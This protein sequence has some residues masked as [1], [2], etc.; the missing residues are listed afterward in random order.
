MVDGQ[1]VWGEDAKAVTFVRVL[2]YLVIVGFHCKS[3][4]TDEAHVDY[5]EPLDEAFGAQADVFEIVGVHVC[6]AEFD[7]SISR[8]DDD[9]ERVR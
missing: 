5:E 6:F 1:V 9:V 3:G 8:C 2:G 4:L 7:C